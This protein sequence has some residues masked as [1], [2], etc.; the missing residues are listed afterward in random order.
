MVKSITCRICLRLQFQ[1][2]GYNEAYDDMTCDIDITLCLYFY[3]I[4]EHVLYSSTYLNNYKIFI[5][6]VRR[7]EILRFD[8]GGV[9][10][11]VRC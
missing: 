11:G 4:F 1:P 5:N 8:I 2:E 10:L 9:I 6:I 3:H 7:V